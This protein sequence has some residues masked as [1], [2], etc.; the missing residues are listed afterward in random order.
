LE[1][2]ALRSPE[3]TDLERIHW[4]SLD[5]WE[6]RERVPAT[7]AYV[8]FKDVAEAIDELGPLEVCNDRVNVFFTR[9]SGRFESD[10]VAIR[11]SGRNVRRILVRQDDFEVEYETFEQ[12]LSHLMSNNAVG[13]AVEYAH[14]KDLKDII[15]VDPMNLDSSRKYTRAEMDIVATMQ[16]M[17]IRDQYIKTNPDDAEF[18]NFFFDMGFTAGRTFSAVQNL[19]TLEVDARAGADAKAQSI[20]RGKKSGSEARRQERLTQFIEQIQATYESN[21]GMRPYEDMVLRVAFDIVVPEGSYGHGRFNDYCTTIR[22]EE[23]FKS[24]FDALFRKS[25]K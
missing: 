1:D 7:G 21:F 23:P 3:T 6:T 17:A 4:I 9:T 25:L 24:R 22:S 15:D 2:E 12:C 10:I 18:I 14:V 19:A 5:N 16:M 20:A 11:Q 13:A 8:T